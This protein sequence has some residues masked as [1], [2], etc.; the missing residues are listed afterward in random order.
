MESDEYKDLLTEDLIKS[1]G[2]DNARRLIGLIKREI[3]ACKDDICAQRR[4]KKWHEL[5]LI[6]LRIQL[7]MP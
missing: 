4:R 6:T 3:P 7:I 5:S 2:I 1:L